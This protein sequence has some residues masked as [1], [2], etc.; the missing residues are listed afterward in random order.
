MKRFL[1]WL[2]DLAETKRENTLA[3]WLERIAFIFLVLMV[4]SAPHSIAAT[5]AAWITG[6]FVWL[7]RQFIKPRPR[8]KF[9]PLDSAMWAFFLWSVV[10]SIFSYDPLVSLNKL[11]GAAVFLIFYFVIYNLRNLRAVYFLSFALIVSCMVNVVWTPV[12]RLI[13]RGVEIH[14]LQPDS[15]LAKA[16]LSNGDTMLE[17]NGKKL[18]TPDDLIEE[19]MQ[20]EITKVRFYRPDFELVVEVKRTDLFEGGTSLEKL[21]FESWKKSRNWRSRGFYGHY[22]TY[23]EVLQLLASLVFGLLVAVLSRRQRGKKKRCRGDE[24]V[25]FELLVSP[26]SRVSF[27]P[28]LLVSSTPFLIISI[29]GMC[30]ALLLTVTRASQLAFIISAFFIVLIGAGR[31]WLLAAV[32]VGVPVILIGLFFLQQSRQVGFF[33]SKDDSTLYRVTMLRDGIRLWTENPRHFIVG[34]GMDSIKLHW[35]EWR[36]FDG[37]RL[38]L[39]HFHSTPVQL[40]VERGLPALLLWLTVLAIYARSLWKGIKTIQ[41]TAHASW[42]SLGILLGCFGG[43]I[44]FFTSGLVHYNLG[45]QEVAMVFFLL[46]GIGMRVTELSSKPDEANSS[47]DTKHR[48][49]RF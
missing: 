48:H 4:V 24:K 34:V 2:D 47:R 46:M 7:I 42:I 49:I 1:T 30:L 29:S 36:L 16:Q 3:Q 18:V 20:N 17:A 40:L 22:T 14:G 15:P 21:G 5:Q 8:L 10:T 25:E 23:A 39:G 44:G 26:L 31:K 43:M 45:D 35:R 28:Y 32:A 41:R 13:G 6:M 11:R 9:T 38:P 33:D 19:I 27:S 37:G 12:Q